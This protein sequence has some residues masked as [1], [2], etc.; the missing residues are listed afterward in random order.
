MVSESETEFWSGMM[1]SPYFHAAGSKVTCARCGKE[2]ITEF[3][4]VGSMVCNEHND[5]SVHGN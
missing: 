3:S 2:M 1:K 5:A 4:L